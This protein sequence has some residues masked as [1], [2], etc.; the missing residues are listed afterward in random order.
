MAPIKQP[1]LGLQR[2]RDYNAYLYY[3]ADGIKYCEAPQLPLTPLSGDLPQLLE[4]TQA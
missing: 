3:P 1:Y 2:F 4:A